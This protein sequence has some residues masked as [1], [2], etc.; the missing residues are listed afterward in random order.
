MAE[1][2]PMLI[3]ALAYAQ[4]GYSVIPLQPDGK[5]AITEWRPYQEK[6]ATQAQ[7]RSWW[8]DTPAANIGIVTGKISGVVVVDLDTYKNPDI[9]S[10][11]IHREAPTDRRSETP[12]GGLHL[13]YKWTQHT[14]SIAGVNGVE[15]FDVRGD[16]GYVAVAPSMVNGS[17]YKWRAKGVLG[18]LLPQA[19][20]PRA[21]APAAESGDTSETSQSKPKWIQGLLAHPP[22]SGSWNNDLTRLAGY[23]CWI[24]M[25]VDITRQ[26]LYTWS[27][28]RMRDGEKSAEF[29]RTI[30]SVYQGDVH[31][32]GHTKHRGPPKTKTD[33]PKF[34]SLRSF[35][36]KYAKDTPPWM[37]EE[38]LPDA[39]CALVVSPPG[40]FKTWLL[41]DLAVAVASGTPFLGR[42]PVRQGPVLFLQ[43]ED[44]HPEIASR[45]ACCLAA[46]VPTIDHSNGPF[47]TYALPEELP[48]YIHPGAE[49]R[50]G[51]D[52]SIE[53]LDEAIR[54]TDARLVVIDPLYS[55]TGTDDFMASAAGHMLPLK[56]MRDNYGC[57]FIIAH[58]TRKL[59]PNSNGES[60]NRMDAWGSQFLNAWLETGWQIRPG[61]ADTVT[62]KR[63]HKVAGADEEIG[64]RFD[65]DSQFLTEVISLEDV[66]SKS[67]SSMMDDISF[68][69]SSEGP[70]TTTDIRNKL[71]GK[72]RLDVVRRSLERMQSRGKASQKNGVWMN[73]EEP[74]TPSLKEVK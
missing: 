73:W 4:Q 17:Q 52:E 14:Q 58:H 46:R 34:M 42:Y 31:R 53:W 67:T 20:R 47:E 25:P 41:T 69:L 38:W 9:D 10:V 68:L 65:I 12:R 66:K 1:M 15:G 13:W 40:A 59:S 16:G 37:V 28:D 64:M 63:H 51:E 7:I 18:P 8:K 44:P 74:T 61:D 60:A 19:A 43:Q 54:K 29:E 45:F 57:G 32:G 6:I 24:D 72:K 27:G 56:R 35:A 30:L 49:F 36:M 50:L 3:A 22:A 71:P 33:G 26:I 2:N 23:F 39:T 55:T 70:M 5:R 62:I 21:V 48:L 11:L